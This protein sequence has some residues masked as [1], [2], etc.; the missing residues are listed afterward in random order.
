MSYTKVA[1]I[2]ANLMFGVGVYVVGVGLLFAFTTE[3]MAQNEAAAHRYL[4]ASNTGEA[5][6]EGLVLIFAALLL[7]VLTEISRNRIEGD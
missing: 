4:A 7:G 6:H 1:R 3:T 5:I 2:V